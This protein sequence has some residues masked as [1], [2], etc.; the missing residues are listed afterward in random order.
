MR[1][2]PSNLFETAA[3]V[4]AI[5]SPHHL[6]HDGYSLLRF[7]L[8]NKLHGMY[9][10]A[11]RSASRQGVTGLSRSCTKPL[12]RRFAS[13]GSPGSKRRSWKGATLR[14]GLAGA[15]VYYYNT[16]SVFAD[17]P[18]N[19]TIPAPSSF[20]DSDLQTVE[21]VIEEKRKQIRAAKNQEA[22]S[23]AK[24]PTRLADD[25]QS[26][27]EAQSTSGLDGGPAALEEEAGQE[28]AFNPETGEINWDCPC[29]GGMAH[30]PCGEEFKTA[31]SCF[32]HSTEEPKGMDCIDKFQGMQECFRKYPD[33]YGAELDEEPA[34][35][36]PDA[37]EQALAEEKENSGELVPSPA[38]GDANVKTNDVS[39][40]R[41]S[42]ALT[43]APKNAAASGGE[44]EK[45]TEIKEA[46]KA[47]PKAEGLKKNEERKEQDM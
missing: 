40:V 31:F 32:V 29:L 45:K 20:A 43:A 27:T 16:S 15:A 2:E 23:A 21:S 42:D 5:S 10:T 37:P 14:W 11:V 28:G 1:S 30:G 47:D 6:L 38:A 44:V 7:T 24:E 36:A 33:I 8:E 17:E 19:K 4:R 39:G 41:T 13:T 9:R 12:N 46:A 25:Q 3:G 22:P 34:D 35:D 18:Q 26:G